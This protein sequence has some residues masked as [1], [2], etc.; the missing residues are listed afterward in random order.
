MAAGAAHRA[1]ER[2]I[3]L[4]KEGRLDPIC[5]ARDV[6]LLAVFGSAT[7]AEGE[8]DDLDV[9]VCFVAGA[10]VVGL[11]DDLIALTGY[12]RIDLVVLD[13]ASPVVRAEAL[14]GVPLYER[15]SGQFARA[16]MAALGERRDTGWLRRLSLEAMAG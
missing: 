6:A 5:R 12:D 7:G 16:Q 2:L 3:A 13:G 8:P 15:E 11:L 4:G 14:T 10:D 1:S 9:G